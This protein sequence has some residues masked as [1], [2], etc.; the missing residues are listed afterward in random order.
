MY[1]NLPMKVIYL[2]AVKDNII[3][4]FKESLWFF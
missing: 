4:H 3:S 1:N 2:W